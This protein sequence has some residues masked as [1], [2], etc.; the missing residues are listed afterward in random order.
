M[1]RGLLGGTFDPIHEGHLALAKAASR[2]LALDE[3]WFLPLGKPWM[4]PEAPVASAEDRAAMILLAIEGHQDFQ[5]SR[6]EIDR[7]GETYTVET[8]EEF[9]QAGILEDEMVFIMGADAMAGLHLWKKV[10]RI[11]KLVRIAVARR[12]GY[13]PLDTS[14]VEA[15]S[16][17]RGLRVVE[18]EMPAVDV[19]GTELRRDIS[20]GVSLLGRIPDRVAAY[21]QQNKLYI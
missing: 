21:I 4:R 19:S 16:A 5:L 18:I 10:D 3:L 15:L 17:F 12:P 11:L 14:K 2:V 6:V 1:R 9:E 20:A 7:A 13:G 8:L